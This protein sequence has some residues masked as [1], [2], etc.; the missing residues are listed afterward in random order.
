MPTRPRSSARRKSNRF[1]DEPKL[2]SLVE[3]EYANE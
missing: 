2:Y 1:L 3:V